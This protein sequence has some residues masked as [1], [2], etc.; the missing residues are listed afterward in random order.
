MNKKVANVILVI[1]TAVCFYFVMG[2]SSDRAKKIYQNE[3]EN[4]N[5]AV[6]ISRDAIKGDY[7]LMTAVELKLLMKNTSFL[8]ID[9][10]PQK[11]YKSNHINGAVNFQL[12]EEKMIKWDE[13]TVGQPLADFKKI[14]GADRDKLIV[15]YG[16]NLK[17]ITSHNGAMWANKTGYTNVIRFSGGMYAWRGAGFQAVTSK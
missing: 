14:L 12:P 6:A 17:S 16:K 1:A 2:D 15:F 4:E 11:R 3:Y 7:R 13:K 5:I 9:T 10:R 8:L